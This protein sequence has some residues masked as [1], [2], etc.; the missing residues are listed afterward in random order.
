MDISLMDSQSL[1]SM[2]ETQRILCTILTRSTLATM[3]SMSVRVTFP[4]GSCS[5]TAPGAMAF[6]AAA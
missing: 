6:P 4:G 5:Y 1:T 2:G 3:S